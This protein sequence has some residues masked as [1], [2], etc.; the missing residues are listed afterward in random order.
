M[1]DKK[2]QRFNWSIIQKGR[3]QLKSDGRIIKGDHRCTSILAWPEDETPE[4]EKA[5][6]TDPCFTQRGYQIALHRLETLGASLDKIGRVFVTHEHHDHIVHIPA[7]MCEIRLTILWLKGLKLAEGLST[8]TY[9]GHFPEQLMLIFRSTDDKQVWVVGDA[10]LDE[11]WLRAWG[12]YWPNGYS[13]AEI[14]QTWR[15]VAAIVAEADVIVPGHGM[16]I[17]VEKPLVEDLLAGFPKAKFMEDCP[18][19]ADSLRERLALLS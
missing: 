16:P 9:P 6:L 10:V 11:E 4:S 5:V 17:Y 12:Y 19:V 3:L 2:L 14:I 18:D 13:R 1:T 7:R 15:T 8:R